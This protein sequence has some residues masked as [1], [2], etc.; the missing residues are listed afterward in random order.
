MAA[1]QA[2]GLAYMKSGDWNNVLLDTDALIQCEPENAEA[3]KMRGQAR[4]AL[5]EYDKAHADFTQAIRLHGDAEVYYLR[6]RAKVQLGDINEAIFDC[7][8][9]TA[10]NPRLADAFYLR[11]TLRLQGSNRTRGLEDRQKAHELN[12]LFPLP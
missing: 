2:R 7:N 5:R 12:P 11:G 4:L 9:A 3:Y 1:R 6:A 10:S 8:C